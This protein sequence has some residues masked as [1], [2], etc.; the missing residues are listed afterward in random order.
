[1]DARPRISLYPSGGLPYMRP[2]TLGSKPSAPPL[3]RDVSWSSAEARPHGQFGR[4]RENARRTVA[5]DTSSK[6]TRRAKTG[7]MSRIEIKTKDGLLCE[8]R[9]GSTL[10]APAN[11]L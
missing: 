11:L 2:T 10:G 1:M 9:A 7:L 3:G 4:E 5:P 8:L 6:R